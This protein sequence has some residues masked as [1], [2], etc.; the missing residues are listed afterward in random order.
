MTAMCEPITATEL[1]QIFAACCI[2]T[3]LIFVAGWF[4][5]RADKMNEMNT[6][7]QK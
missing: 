1:A 4:T 3:T 6:R 7:E 2:A 5:G